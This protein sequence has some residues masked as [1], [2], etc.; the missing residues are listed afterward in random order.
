M[1]HDNNPPTFLRCCYDRDQQ[2]STCC[3]PCSLR[4]DIN[5][6]IP[7]CSVILGQRRR[8]QRIRSWTFLERRWDG[9]QG[10]NLDND[11][12]VEYGGLMIILSQSTKYV[13]I[14][15][16]HTIFLL[17]VRFSVHCNTLR[18]GKCNDASGNSQ[19]VS[20]AAGY[21]SDG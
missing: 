13:K 10:P 16:C 20:V 8:E 3:M 15:V 4:C 12:A 14:T 11:D 7:S 6:T 1:Q 18:D 21:C 9:L 5:S 2:K 17:S 19:N